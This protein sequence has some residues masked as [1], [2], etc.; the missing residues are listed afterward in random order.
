MAKR[1]TRAITVLA[2]PALIV[3]AIACGS[4]FE[5]PPEPPSPPGASASQSEI[6]TYEE[7]YAEYQEENRDYQYYWDEH[8]RGYDD[9]RHR[10]CAAIEQVFAGSSP[11]GARNRLD[12]YEDGL[13]KETAREQGYAKGFAEGREFAADALDNDDATFFDFA[14]VCQ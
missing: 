13:P 11:S 5:N 7:Q 9:G 14:I 1:I 4:S 8:E 10:T 3:T 2:M 6:A 12:R